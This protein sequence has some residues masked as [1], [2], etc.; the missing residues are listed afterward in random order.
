MLTSKDSKGPPR[1]E[2][3]LANNLNQN[4]NYKIRTSLLQKMF[5]FAKT[6]HL[7]KR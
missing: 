7:C 3:H 5:T 6:N 2:P 1:G 4:T